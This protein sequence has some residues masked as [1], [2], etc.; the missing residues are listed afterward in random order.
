MTEPNDV[1]E[2]CGAAHGVHM[3]ACPA[4]ERDEY[5]AVLAAIICRTTD[6]D[7][8][9]CAASVLGLSVEDIR[10]RRALRGKTPWPNKPGD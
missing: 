4:G 9:L 5:E 7:A 1:C 3:A 2:W 8:M 6:P 10:R